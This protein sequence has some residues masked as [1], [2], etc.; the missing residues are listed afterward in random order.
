MVAKRNCVYRGARA[1]AGTQNPEY[2]LRINTELKC[3]TFTLR[4]LSV[5]SD[6]LVIGQLFA[7]RRVVVPEMRDFGTGSRRL[8]LE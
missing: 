4:F 5:L 6:R 1:R 8:L 7:C 3:G 2:E